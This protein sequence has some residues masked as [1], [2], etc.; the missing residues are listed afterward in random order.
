MG[1]SPGILPGRVTLENG[2]DDFSD[3]WG[4]L[5]T[6]R[7]YDAIGTLE[8]AV[9]GKIKVLITLGADV[10]RDVPDRNLV[11]RAL[12]Q[13]PTLI[14]IG[15][16]TDATTEAAHVVLPVAGEGERNGT[17]TNLEGRVAPTTQKVVPPGVA[18]PAWM[19]A[20][21]LAR[22][23]GGDL[24]FNDLA[25]VTEEIGLVAPAYRGL[26]LSL[27]NS[28]ARRDGVVVPIGSTPVRI[29]SRTLDPIATPGIASVDEQGAPIRL[30]KTITS[31]PF[32]ETAPA[33]GS[34]VQELMRALRNAP[35]VVAPKADAYT[36]RLSIR[37]SL[38]D[39]GTLMQSSTSLAP[40][41]QPFGLHVH[42]RELAGL[43][44]ANGGML[45]I[46]SSRGAQ[47]ITAIA[48]DSLE[49]QVVVL[50]ARAESENSVGA[51]DLVD[52]R[53]LVVDVRLESI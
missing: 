2:R 27:A 9:A 21:E 40:L 12:A 34:G 39:Q 18:W 51:F 44:V 33:T 36:Y 1:L 45:R 32:A 7:G 24:G 52:A 8:A 26:N 22:R 47:E 53:D 31:A 16:H 14:A 28:D 42:P 29:G 6:H 41:A 35:L 23:L 43:G 5:P 3:A 30:G 19:V 20:S 49:H 48:D 13:V 17:V 37:R 38:F 50:G 11:T 25:G 4:S 15:T 10:L 46:R